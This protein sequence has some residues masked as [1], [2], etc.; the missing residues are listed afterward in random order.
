M[1]WVEKGTSTW[2]GRDRRNDFCYRVS[3]QDPVSLGGLLVSDG[4]SVYLGSWPYGPS[5]KTETN[6]DSNFIQT[7]NGF[8]DPSW[9]FRNWWMDRR[10]GGH[11]LSFNN[12]RTFAIR[13]RGF[14]HRWT[15][16]ASLHEPGTQF[17]L[18]AQSKT[19]PDEFFTLRSTVKVPADWVREIPVVG[20]AMALSQRTLFVAGAPDEVGAKGGLLMAYS[21]KTGEPLTEY[22][23]DAPPVFDGMAA[24]AGRLYL[25]TKDGRV[26]CFADG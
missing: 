18:L 16:K 19:I 23:L 13:M 9:N 8:F 22:K 20:D 1:D 10:V 26:L 21:A 15:Y 3:Y 4:A 6:S 14:A 12:E 11:L 25:S 2:W 24:T 17:E 7:K 5:R